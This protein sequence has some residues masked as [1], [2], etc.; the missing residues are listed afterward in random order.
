MTKKL[1]LI[2]KLP[3]SFITRRCSERKNA[4]I[5]KQTHFFSQSSRSYIALTLRSLRVNNGCKNSSNFPFGHFALKLSK[6]TVL[7]DIQTLIITLKKLNLKV[8]TE[9]VWN[10]FWQRWAIKNLAK[11]FW[12]III[13]DESLFRPSQTTMSTWPK[14]T[15]TYSMWYIDTLDF[16][17]WRKRMKRLAFSSI[18]SKIDA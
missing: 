4:A 7:K 8:F 18:Q 5:S 14:K 11:Y 16:G 17:N 9:T 12:F 3:R 6:I 10:V 15:T 13:V 2:L 1:V